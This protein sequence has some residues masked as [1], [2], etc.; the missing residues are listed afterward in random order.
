VESAWVLR[1]LGERLLYLHCLI[2]YGDRDA[3]YGLLQELQRGGVCGR[4]SFVLTQDGWQ[5]MHALAQA[6][7]QR[8]H[9]TGPFVQELSWTALGGPQGYVVDGVA[10]EF[11]LVIPVVFEQYGERLSL[12]Q[13]WLRMY[14][15]MHLG[16]WKYL[17]RKQR[18]WPVNGKTYVKRALA[19]LSE[20]GLFRQ[21]RVWY[22]P[23]LQE[24]LEIFLLVKLEQPAA[25]HDFLR[26]VEKEAPIVHVY[27][28]C[29][30]TTL[31]RCVG[32]TGLLYALVELVPEEM[33]DNVELFVRDRNL[34]AR[35]QERVRFAYDLLFDV[36]RKA[37][38]FPK[39]KILQCLGVTHGTA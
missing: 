19:V 39:E 32:D 24:S 4:F 6:F 13:V 14:E 2:P 7:D 28:G 5:G 17:P 21:N 12:Q 22:A 15:R 26:S 34:T 31:L 25:M 23:F 11:P 1:R 8:G 38:V 10:E 27:P 37:W 29:D 33:A 20:R 3:V 18:K 16:V 36:E 35:Q 30:G 9:V